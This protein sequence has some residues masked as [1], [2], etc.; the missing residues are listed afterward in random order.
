[1]EKEITSVLKYLRGFFPKIYVGG[2]YS[3]NLVLNYN[4][5]MYDVDIF[6]LGK[7]TLE[8]WAL[9]YI[10]K[11]IFD[12][13]Q[14]T[15]DDADGKYVIEHQYRLVKAIKNNISFDLIFM[16]TD[17]YGL[18]C[19]TASDLSMFYHKITFSDERLLQLNPNYNKQSLVNLAIN[20]RCEINK[21][22]CT[23][24]HFRKI[25]DRC[26]KLGLDILLVT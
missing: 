26:N 2:S 12:T 22:K 24:E 11:G 5:D 21:S 13:V 3:T 20:K 19:S 16:D 25:T 17:Y 9:E 8:S 23:A 6:I 7:R 18:I 15:N 14:I 4:L 10:L 1:M